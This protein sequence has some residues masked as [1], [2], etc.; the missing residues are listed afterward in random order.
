MTAPDASRRLE[1]FAADLLGTGRVAVETA[2]PEGEI[3]VLRVPEGLL[4]AVL[5]PGP[6][7]RI[8][9]KA[10]RLGYEYAALDLDLWDE[11]GTGS[12]GTHED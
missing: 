4:G 2:G 6:R 3:A 1:E 5:G 11:A 7:A 8:C 10:R 12:G 9:Q